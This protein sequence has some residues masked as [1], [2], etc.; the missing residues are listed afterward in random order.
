MKKE[1]HRKPWDYF[2]LSANVSHWIDSG[3]ECQQNI[4]TV[5]DLALL[6]SL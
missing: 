2:T 4:L 5:V 3:F 6:R 1:L